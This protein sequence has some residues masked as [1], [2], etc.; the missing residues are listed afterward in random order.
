MTEKLQSKTPEDWKNIYLQRF[1]D[2]HDNFSDEIPEEMINGENPENHKY[3]VRGN[4]F[5]GV[6]NSLDFIAS[7]NLF[8]EDFNEEWRS[9]FKAY[10]KRMTESN[11]NIRTT[12]EEIDTVNNLLKKAQ[13]LL[14]IKQ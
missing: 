14:V 5:A 7:Q 1:K 13:E 4:W 9:F 12:K 3:K 2:F 10:G 8:P 11:E 6:R